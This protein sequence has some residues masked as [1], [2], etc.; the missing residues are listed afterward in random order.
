MKN[1][2]MKNTSL[3]SN[4]GTKRITLLAG[5]FA[6]TIYV[7]SIPLSA[8][9]Q[10][11][12]AFASTR[13]FPD[14]IHLMN[15]DGSNVM[16]I[17]G[18][19]SFE[20]T[21]SINRRATK[22][23]YISGTSQ[24]Y[25]VN[26]D[27]TNQMALTPVLS[28]PGSNQAATNADP[29]FNYAGSKIAFDSNRDIPLGDET[30][31]DI[32]VMNTDGSGV[33]RLTAN[34][35]GNAQPSYSPDDSKI[36][37]STN[38]DGNSEIYVMNADG[39]APVRLTNNS[40]YDVFPQFTPDSSKIVY[41]SN[42][43]IWIMNADGTN[44][45]NLTGN[46]LE[47]FRPTVSPDGSKIAFASRRDGNWEIYVMN[48]DGTNQVNITNNPAIDFFPSWS[49]TPQPVTLTVTNTNDSGA[50]S[51]RQAIADAA[52]GDRVNFNLTGCPCTITLTTGGLVI[53]KNL[54]I[55]GP[56]A[57]QLKVSAN[58][59]APF[60]FQVNSG[61]TAAFSGLTISEAGGPAG[62]AS[63]G[64]GV[65]NSGNLTVTDCTVSGN[66]NQAGG[67]AGLQNT[68]ILKVVGCFITGNVTTTIVGGGG[69]SNL[70]GTLIVKNST[71]SGNEGG[72]NGGGIRNIDSGTAYVSNS[73]ISGNRAFR[74]GAIE[75]GTGSFT[76]VNST[77]V[78]NNSNQFEAGINGGGTF[79]ISNSII[80]ANRQIIAG[81][82]GPE[83]NLNIGNGIFKYNVISSLGPNPSP[84]ICYPLN[85]VDGNIVGAGGCGVLDVNVILN[86]AL[87]DNG[88]LTPTHALF[89]TSPAINAGSNPLAVDEN[90]SP[91]AF[92]QRGTGF[93]RIIGGLVDIGA[94][95]L[96]LDSDGDN[97]PD[98]NDNC[99]LVSNPDQLDT[100]MDGAG[101]ACD[102]D[103]DGDNVADTIDNCPLHS[104]PDQADFDLDG[105][106]DACDAQTG[107][108]STKEQ[109]KEGSWQRF[110]YP[111]T[112]VNQGD[113]LRFLLR[114][115]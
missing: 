74:G 15:P 46:G 4:Y 99:P 77:V 52:S 53:D 98:D 83:S 78:L 72:G 73:T 65:L 111:R 66:R 11:K 55:D 62:T 2:G 59:S 7:L 10:E 58:Y 54:T 14:R 104:N 31:S 76:L 63:S 61:V 23:T 26:T 29:A 30:S 82:T 32:Y 108:P 86:T 41:T 81:F 112:F 40:A 91:L 9:A 110:N 79:I 87:A 43:D 60:V 89:E 105:I 68:G 21:P 20:F 50:G 1:F 35:G 5:L 8:S 36:V 109:C 18:G 28:R 102:A 56:G 3:T 16:P 22:V 75:Q 115:F 33:T 49:G 42:N 96:L 39:T 13:T 88:G 95:E 64:N 19:G 97:V 90:N 47:N 100:D 92:D 24:I 93:P 38:R 51:L 106:G 25:L 57:A 34:A 84:M 101:N 85:G 67:G 103:D 37:F 17:S 113:C 71:V 27:G 69:I 44:Q 70:G 107:P 45:V 94:F 6:L 114:G 12:I 48:S 80:A